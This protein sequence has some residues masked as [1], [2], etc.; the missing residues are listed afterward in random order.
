MR[1]ILLLVVAWAAVACVTEP[2]LDP[3]YCYAAGDTSFYTPVIWHADS[4][5]L[6]CR[7][8]IES[9]SRCEA[10]PVKRYGTKDCAVGTKWPR[11]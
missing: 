6:E 10:Y 2:K 4:T 8:V 3:R 1:P 7:W 5:T 9:T 11:H